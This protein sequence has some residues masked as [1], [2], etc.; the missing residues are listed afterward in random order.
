MHGLQLPR[1]AFSEVSTHSML[2]AAKII[3]SKKAFSFRDV[4][5]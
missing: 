1:D 4:K 2:L 5:T 3:D